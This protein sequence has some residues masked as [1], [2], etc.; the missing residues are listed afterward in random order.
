MLSAMSD[1]SL[2]CS[3]PITARHARH[4]AL[5]MTEKTGDARSLG[6][7]ASLHRMPGWVTCSDA[8]CEDCVESDAI[9]ITCWA[10]PS[11]ASKL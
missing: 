10:E 11:P 3:S 8:N 4:Q 5:E 7:C 1:S 2:N 6:S 9:G